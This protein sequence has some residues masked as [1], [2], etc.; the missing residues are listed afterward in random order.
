MF[1]GSGSA[2]KPR[3]D[4]APGSGGSSGPQTA[5]AAGG[6]SSAGSSG[7]PLNAQS[8]R[9]FAAAVGG[10]S[11]KRGSPAPPAFLRPQ[12][13]RGTAVIEHDDYASMER[14]A[15]DSA[16]P[17]LLYIDMRSTSLSPEA[18]L[19]LAYPVVQDQV[20][21]FQLFAAQKTIGLVFASSEARLRAIGKPLGESGLTMYPAP[22]QKP[23]LLKLTLQGVPFWSVDSIKQELPKLL[24]PFGALVFLAPMV[25]VTHGWYS[26]QWHATIARPE[27][28]TDLPAELLTLAG[29]TV[30]VDIPGQRR[31]CRHCEASVH[32][33]SSCRQGQ[34]EKSRQNQ[35]ARDAAAAQP[36]LQQQPPSNPPPPQDPQQP[37]GQ[38]PQDPQLDTT[39]P[40]LSVDWQT[41]TLL[42]AAQTANAT[43]QPSAFDENEMETETVEISRET[44]LARAHD[45]LRAESADPGS[46]DQTLVVAAQRFV[47]EAARSGS[48]EQ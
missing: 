38:Q 14:P 37:T 22:P 18:V 20:V 8:R 29:A 21:G 32:V 24:E 25:T 46:Q 43:G 3:I 42:R 13:R 10:S 40:Y 27:G 6:S 17:H 16:A 48:G 36:Q 9:S 23:N 31:Y 11:A 33:K 1:T 7:G 28:S 19:D 45:I 47:R 15:P 30:I 39:R 44:Q 4:A 2:K 5:G 26:D 41:Q 34:R 12:L 35:Q